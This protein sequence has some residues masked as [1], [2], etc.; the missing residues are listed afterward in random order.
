MTTATHA[1]W[2]CLALTGCGAHSGA[3]ERVCIAHAGARCTGWE[4]H[5]TEQGRFFREVADDRNRAT[6]ARDG[7]AV[8]PAQI[9][10]ESTT[11]YLDRVQH[12]NSGSTASAGR[13][14]SFPAIPSWGSS[15]S[16]GPSF[17]GSSF[18]GP[19]FGGSTFGGSSSGSRR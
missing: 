5:E 19:S 13:G 16:G 9:P 12:A 15:P 6:A 3:T 4:V 1:L 11:H 17:G 18:G 2:L 14:S 10:G 8:F 7:T